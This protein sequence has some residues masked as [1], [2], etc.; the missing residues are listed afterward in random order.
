[1]SIL[2]TCPYSLT[3]AYLLLTTNYPL[4][5]TNYLLPRHPYCKPTKIK[6]LKENDVQNSLRR[7]YRWSLKIT[8]PL[9]NLPNAPEGESSLSGE[10]PYQNNERRV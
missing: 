4:L 6:G 8:N 2:F 7:A 10:S 1:M 3:T 5:K 9:K